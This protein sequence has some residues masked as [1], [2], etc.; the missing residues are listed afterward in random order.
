MPGSQHTGRHTADAGDNFY[1]FA[2]SVASGALPEALTA[3][4]YADDRAS[5]KLVSMLDG[6]EGSPNTSA[7][8]K[9]ACTFFN[10]LLRP[11]SPQV[12]SQGFVRGLLQEIDAVDSHAGMASWFSRPPSVVRGPIRC[13]FSASSERPPRRSISVQGWTR[14]ATRPPLSAPPNASAEERDAVVVSRAI[15]AELAELTAG[16]TSGHQSTTISIE[17]LVETCPNYPW[18]AVVAAAGLDRVRRM[19]VWD[20]DLI[21]TLAEYFSSKPVA[22]WKTFARVM[23]RRSADELEGLTPVAAARMAASLYPAAFHARGSPEVRPA[24]MSAVTQLFLSVRAAFIEMARRTTAL[25]SDERQHVVQ[26]LEDL[27]FVL[28]WSPV[29]EPA[30]SPIETDAEPLSTLAD[31]RARRWRAGVAAIGQLLP[32]TEFLPPLHAATASYDS[33]FHAVLVSPALL[34]EPFYTGTDTAATYGALGAV[35]GHEIAH[36]VLV[37]LGIA[38]GDPSPSAKHW[39]K[40][41]GNRLSARRLNRPESG[42]IQSSD[43]ESTIAKE[44]TIEDVCDRLGLAAAVAAFAADGRQFGRCRELFMSWAVMWRDWSPGADEPYTDG[45]TRTNETVRDIDAW[46]DAFSIAHSAG[47]FLPAN[48]RIRPL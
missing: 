29:D 5:K 13:V 44:R 22:D 3:F 33:D 1:R 26:R 11:A 37:G 45:E 47:M 24:D 20:P 48:E 38:G 42:Q 35:I 28:P 23:V 4:A 14:D 7:Q 18:D 2:Q 16:T 15:A 32:M 34:C 46:Y 19:T 12:D 39:W 31:V 6:F 41:L 8:Q 25:P 40:A 30:W 27:S 36:A 9:A 21:R 17:A 10:R 43:E